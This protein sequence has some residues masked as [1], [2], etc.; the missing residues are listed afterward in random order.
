MEKSKVVNVVEFVETT[1]IDDRFFEQPYYLA[2][3]KGSGTGLRGASRSA[4]QERQ[5]RHRDDDSA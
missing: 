1:S 2:P 5:G 4:A 3:A